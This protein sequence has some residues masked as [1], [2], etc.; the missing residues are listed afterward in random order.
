MVFWKEGL[1]GINQSYLHGSL[2]LFSPSITECGA[3]AAAIS[4]RKVSPDLTL[5]LTLTLTLTPT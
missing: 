3:V 5:A 1:S 4:G 2:G